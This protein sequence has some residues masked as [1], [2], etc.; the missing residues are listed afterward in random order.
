[1]RCFHY[2]IALNSSDVY[3]GILPLRQPF[4]S[5]H[6][7]ASSN[8]V[9]KLERRHKRICIPSHICTLIHIH[10]HMH[11][12]FVAYSM[13]LYVTTT[14]TTTH[15]NGTGYRVIRYIIRFILCDTERLTQVL[16]V[17]SRMRKRRRSSSSRGEWKKVYVNACVRTNT[18]V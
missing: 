3:V 14:A 2:F 1:M 9:N 13:C 11:T 15:I 7:I 16:S 5:T 10:I 18:S 12:C 17:K 8:I 4:N 6:R